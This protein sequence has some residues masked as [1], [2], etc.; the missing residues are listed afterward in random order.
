MSIVD[1]IFSEDLQTCAMNQ[2]KS[3]KQY[4]KPILEELG[5][6]R[7]LTLGGSPGVGESGGAYPE[8][9]QT[10]PRNLPPGF[11]PP[12]SGISKP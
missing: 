5:D 8:F 6:L 12:P 4:L 9:P 3:R 11:P 2:R 10:S 7:T 1:G